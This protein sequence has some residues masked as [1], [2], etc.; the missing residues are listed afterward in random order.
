MKLARRD[1]A[2][3]YPGGPSTLIGTG[4][5]ST[6]DLAAFANGAAVRY[7]DLNDNYASPTAGTVHPSDHIAPCLAVAESE[8]AN[9]QQLVTAILLAYEIN[10]LAYPAVVYA[11][12]AISAVSRESKSPPPDA[13]RWKRSTTSPH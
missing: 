12:T 1:V 2:S 13:G 9:G 8:H 11:Q 6:P 3:L 4:K 10:Y 7:Y 5:R